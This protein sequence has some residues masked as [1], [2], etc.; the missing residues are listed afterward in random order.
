[1]YRPPQ[2]LPRV[3]AGNGNV[4]VSRLASDFLILFGA[5][6]L[7]ASVPLVVLRTL[8]PRPA[9]F[10]ILALGTAIGLLFLARPRWILPTFIAIVWTSVDQ[11]FFA[12][13]PSPVEVGGL[14]LLCYASLQAVRRLN[15]TSEVLWV[16]ALLAL[17]LLASGLL[18]PEGAGAAI[19]KLKNLSFLFLVALTLRTTDEIERVP[20]TLT[21]VAIFLGAGAVYSVLVQPTPLFPL[22]ERHFPW[23]PPVSARAAGPFLDPNFFGLGMATLMPFCLY[24]VSKGGGRMALGITGGVCLVGGILATGSRGSLLAAGV[25]I[26]AAGLLIPA[27]RLRVAAVLVVVAGVVSLPLFATQREAAAERSVEGRATENMVAVAMLAD[28]PLVGVGPAQ[29]PIRYRE[30]S[31]VIGNDPRPVRSPH[32]LPLEIA[33]E[34]GLAGIVGWLVAGFAVFRFAFSRGIWRL[35]VGRTIVLAMATY[36]VGSLFLH[37]SQLRLLYILIGM[38]LALAAALPRP[39]PRAVAR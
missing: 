2:S 23:D 38:L 34:Q 12:G 30:Y 11:G 22:A 18:S 13:L 8:S 33:A 35:F 9:M 20:T 39:G 19:E 1:V 31:R 21:L 5:G 4:P 7:A 17:P 6:L 28:H 10:P 26:V 37:G 16:C 15:Y 36:M 32:S 14:A 25:A 29:Y 3:A 27:R 24:L